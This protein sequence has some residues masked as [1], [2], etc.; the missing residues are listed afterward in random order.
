M[1]RPS[2]MFSVSSERNPLLQYCLKTSLHVQT[3]RPKSFRTSS[4]ALLK[5]VQ[6]DVA[7]LVGSRVVNGRT[8]DDVIVVELHERLDVAQLEGRD[9]D[10]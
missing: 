5:L 4:E 6:V 1:K 3:F 8:D 7:K 9:G 10:L 2:S